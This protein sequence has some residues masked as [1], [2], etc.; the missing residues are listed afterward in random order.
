M[1]TRTPEDSQ[2]ILTQDLFKRFLESRPSGISS[3][4]IEASLYPE[5]LVR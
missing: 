2:L 3:R 1:V 5:G 4:S